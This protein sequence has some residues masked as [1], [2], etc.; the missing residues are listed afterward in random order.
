MTESQEEIR[1]DQAE[2]AA[3]PDEALGVL[4]GENEGLKTRLAEAADAIESRRDSERLLHEAQDENHRLRARLAA[5]ATN[6][7]IAQAAEQLGVPPAIAGIHA[8]KFKC[9]LDAEGLA[10][11]TPDP[12]EFFESELKRDPMLRSAVEESAAAKRTSAAVDGSMGLDDAPPAELLVSLD[13]NPNRKT[14]FIAR[15]GVKAYLDL[16]DRARRC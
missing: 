6:A 15:H 16:C 7:A 3:E 13:R 5:S 10:T 14:R 8:H 4:R 1:T 2:P 11:I 9:R 12:V